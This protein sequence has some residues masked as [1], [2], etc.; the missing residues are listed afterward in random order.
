VSTSNL[1]AETKTEKFRPQSRIA[2]SSTA[3]WGRNGIRGIRRCIEEFA[4]NVCGT[5]D[6]SEAVR[7]ANVADSLSSAVPP[8]CHLIPR[9]K[10]LAELL[11]LAAEDSGVPVNQS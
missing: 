8:P 4:W 11:L 3:T 1:R 9:P 7:Y 6:R 5:A 2:S 10:E